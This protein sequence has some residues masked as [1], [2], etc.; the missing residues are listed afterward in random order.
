EKYWK[1]GEPCPIA[2]VL[3]CEPLT[4]SAGRDGPA[5]KKYDYAGGLRGEP[6]EVLAAPRTGLF[7]PAEAEIVLEGELPSPEEESVFEG[8]FGE[9]PGYYSHSG[10]ECVVRV[11]EI[12]YRPSPIIYGSPPLRPMLSW[13]Q[14]GKPAQF[15]VEHLE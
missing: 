5:G 3:G 14:G 7:I 10:M 9:W 2:V 4:Y 1:R 11:Q 15:M 8:P 6:V 13:E 12:H